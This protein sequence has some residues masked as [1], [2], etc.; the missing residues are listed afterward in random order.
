[1]KD[2]VSKLIEAIAE[3]LKQSDRTT[4]DL[5]YDL[6][7]DYHQVYD[8]MTGRHKPQGDSLMA[9]MAWY[10]NNKPNAAVRQSQAA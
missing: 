9:L 8:W 5:A 6:S 1:M 2:R 4:A 10:N 3:A 7:K